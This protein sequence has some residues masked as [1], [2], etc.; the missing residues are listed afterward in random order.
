MKPNLQLAA[1]SDPSLVDKLM[2]W[3]HSGI[4]FNHK[5]I[6]LIDKLYKPDVPSKLRNTALK[7]VEKKHGGIQPAYDM[8]ES[9]T[10]EQSVYLKKLRQYSVNGLT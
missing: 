10:L 5:Q 1:Q 8:Y 7:E 4:I 6:R 2:K 9:L 3:M